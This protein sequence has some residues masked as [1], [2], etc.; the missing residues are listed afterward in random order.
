F[1]PSW[2]CP[3]PR[4]LRFEHLHWADR[5][6]RCKRSEPIRPVQDAKHLNQRTQRGAFSAL[7]VLNSVERNSGPF[8]QLLLIEIQ[9]EP[10]SA[11]LL[12][13][14]R[15]PFSGRRHYHTSFNIPI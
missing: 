10:K 6:G 3:P 5:N 2:R 15:L 12:S 1:R 13:E 14:F 9:S 4:R 11:D 8:R 7:E